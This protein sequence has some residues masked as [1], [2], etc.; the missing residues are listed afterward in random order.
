MCYKVT[1]FICVVHSPFKHKKWVKSLLH[2]NWYINPGRQN[3]QKISQISK[4]GS[5]PKAVPEGEH[6]QL[7]ELLLLSIL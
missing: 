7:A 6:L 2:F 1:Q 5:L 4:L 3:R